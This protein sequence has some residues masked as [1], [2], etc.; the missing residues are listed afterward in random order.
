MTTYKEKRKNDNELLKNNVKRIK[1][2]VVNNTNF[3]NVNSIYT[4]N[5]IILYKL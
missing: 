2:N 1:P 3:E 5:I 4:F